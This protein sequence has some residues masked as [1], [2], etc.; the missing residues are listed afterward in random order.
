[1]REPAP[2][3][4]DRSLLTTW[5]CR[6]SRHRAA[7]QCAAVVLSVQDGELRALPEA[8]G[9]SLFCGR[10]VRAASVSSSLSTGLFWV[11]VPPVLPTRSG[12]SEAGHPPGGR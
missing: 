3:R 12:A 10:S 11:A 2:A 4:Q 6:Q 9:S 5:L 1:M 7:G 8:R